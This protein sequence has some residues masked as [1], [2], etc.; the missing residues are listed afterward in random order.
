MKTTD[1]IY[2]VQLEIFR[3]TT[4]GNDGTQ[5]VIILSWMFFV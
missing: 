3:D 1:K 4:A 5:Q 2:V